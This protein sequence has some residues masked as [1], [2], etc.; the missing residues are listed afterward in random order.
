MCYMCLVHTYSYIN[1]MEFTVKV[2]TIKEKK[3]KAPYYSILFNY[4]MGTLSLF[5]FLFVYRSTNYG[6]T[7]TRINTRLEPSGSIRLYPFIHV[8]PS[9]RTQVNKR[10]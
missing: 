1:V 7:F 2:H 3:V 10:P 9:D 4:H 6:D 8:N 5:L